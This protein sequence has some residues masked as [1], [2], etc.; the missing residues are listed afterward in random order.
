MKKI[1]GTCF[2][3]LIVFF[4]LGSA[5]MAAG[6]VDCNEFISVSDA[7]YLLNY[8]FVHGPAPCTGCL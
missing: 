3:V 2:L 8:L 4:S 1:R 5:A 7:I 6:K